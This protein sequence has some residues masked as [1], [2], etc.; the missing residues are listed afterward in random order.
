MRTILRQI[1][2]LY[3]RFLGSPIR[4]E[5]TGQFLGR[6]LILVWRGRIHVIG[7]TGVGPLKPVFC[8]QNR[9]RYWTQAVGFTR[10]SAPDFPRQRAE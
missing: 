6:A 9:I 2:N 3:I 1:G 8:S 5:A 10:P 7:F 4:D